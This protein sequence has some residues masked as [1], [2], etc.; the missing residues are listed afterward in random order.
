MMKAFPYDKLWRGHPL[1]NANV[2]QTAWESWNAL[3]IAIGKAISKVV[4]YEKKVHPCSCILNRPAHLNEMTVE[5]ASWAFAALAS[6]HLR[7]FSHSKHVFFPFCHKSPCA[8]QGCIFF[9]KIEFFI[10][11]YLEHRVFFFIK[12]GSFYKRSAHLHEIHHFLKVKDW[13]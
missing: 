4:G 3:S 12:R 6:P 13:F 8:V 7:W 5:T 2:L 9:P 1:L 10:N 11:H